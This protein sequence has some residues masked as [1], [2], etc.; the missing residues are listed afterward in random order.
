M[1]AR[2]HRFDVWLVFDKSNACVYMR[3]RKVGSLAERCCKNNV[4]D[5][6]LSPKST[7]NRSQGTPIHV[8]EIHNWAGWG[9]LFLRGNSR[10]S[11]TRLVFLRGLPFMLVEEIP[12]LERTGL[13]TSPEP[14]WIHEEISNWYQRGLFWGLMFDSFCVFC[15]AE[16]D[17]ER[18][19]R[20]FLQLLYKSV[21][22]TR[23]ND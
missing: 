22:N 7:Q 21:K 9:F 16:V 18:W 19:A 3:L 1:H 10:V 11:W 13:M 12:K 6:F 23:Q 4:V 5:F 20:Y 8:E 17:F 2:D 15:Y 14:M